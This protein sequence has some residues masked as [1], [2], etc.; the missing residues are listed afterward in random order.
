VLCTKIFPTSR[1][2]FNAVTAAPGGVARTLLNKKKYRGQYCE[3]KIKE[4]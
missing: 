3:R 1:I 4:K 2:F